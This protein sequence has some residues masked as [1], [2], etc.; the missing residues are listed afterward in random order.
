M[1]ARISTLL[2]AAVATS[3]LALGGCSH[4]ATSTVV[5]EDNGLPRHN[6]TSKSKRWQYKFVYFP[7][8]DVYFEPYTSTYYWYDGDFWY[9]G[10]ELPDHVDVSFVEPQIV[11]L[12]DN[13]P[14]MNHGTVVAKHFGGW[15]T[16]KPGATDISFWGDWHQVGWE[17]DC[18]DTAADYAGMCGGEQF[19]STTGQPMMCDPASCPVAQEQMNGEKTA[20]SNP[21]ETEMTT[22]AE[23]EMDN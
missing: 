10:A 11:R 17:A 5:W 16:V 9:E 15:K 3:V 4:N 7:G 18:T 23:S 21:A 13:K 2:T 14:Y 8:E 22:M 1:S 6:P 20:S 12:R 19:M